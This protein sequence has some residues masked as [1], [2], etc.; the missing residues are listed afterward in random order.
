[1][2]PDG[3]VP[4]CKAPRMP[5]GLRQLR[6]F[7]AIADAGAFSRA[8]ETLS[9]AQSALSHHV[10]ELE[11][12]LGVKLL[13]RRARG[14]ALTTAGRRLYEHASAIMASLERAEADVRTL[15]EAASGPVAVG[16][17]HTAVEAAALP[18]MEG[19][20]RACPAV[21]LTVAEGLSPTLIDRVLTANLDIAVVY[22]PPK[23]SRLS[24]RALL[25]EDLYLV[26][27]T[28]IIGKSKRA[29]AFADI[30]QH[31]VLG[32]S[33]VPASRAVIH[34]QVLRNQIN[35][36]P[37]LDIDSLN[38]LRV[39]LEAGLGS[40]ILARATVAS[41]IATG[42]LHARRIVSPDLKRELHI[43]SLIDRPKVKAF[44]EVGQVI[45]D[46]IQAEA[47]HGRWKASVIRKAS[48]A[49]I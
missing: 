40:A 2:N 13:E 33:P 19:V 43:I 28:D 20:R 32:L 26:G 30:P 16:L 39:A 45:A 37:S 31:S 9:V 44:T 47:A 41:S 34:A 22:N 18:I 14:I 8:A 17:T 36:N 12:I 24:C 15:T 38:A 21:R 10:A 46:I 48:K 6:Y 5:L 23:D 29:I 25:E 7:I 1:M 35:P 11:T 4:I 42:A 27:R 3:S 49:A